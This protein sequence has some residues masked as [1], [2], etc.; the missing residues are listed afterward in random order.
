VSQPKKKTLYATSLHPFL[1]IKRQFSLSLFAPS[2]YTLDDV[3]ETIDSSAQAVDE[4][5]E[6]PRYSLITPVLNALAEKM[7]VKHWGQ[8]SLRDGTLAQGST[9]WALIYRGLPVFIIEGKQNIDNN[10]VAQLVLQM[11]EAYMKLG[12][13]GTEDDPW[14]M[15]GMV[16]TAIKVVFIKTLFCEED[17]IEIKRNKNVF[18]IPHNKRTKVNEYIGGVSPVARHMEA[19]LDEQKTQVDK[20]L[21]ARVQQQ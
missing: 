12:Q 11:H 13:R 4:M 16:T 3:K 20:A 9:D 17:L 8:Y 10:G 14:V 6:I 2:Y 18:Y 19:M 7:G 15:Y 5:L 1:A 21:D